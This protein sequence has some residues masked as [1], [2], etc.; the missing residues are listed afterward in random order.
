MMA[1]GF[2]C[3]SVIFLL[4]GASFFTLVF[5]GLDGHVWIEEVFRH[6][7]AG[8]VGFLIFLNVAIFLLAFFLDFFEIAFIVLPLIGPIA[9][10]MGVD[11]VWLAVVLA[12]NLQTSFM[13]PPIWHCPL[14]LAQRDASNRGDRQHLLGRRCRHRRYRAGNGEC[15][16]PAALSKDITAGNCHLSTSQW[17]AGNSRASMVV[18]GTRMNQSA[19][20]DCRCP[21]ILSSRNADD[22]SSLPH[23]PDRAARPP[24]ALP[25]G[26]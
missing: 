13:H 16:E 6:L 23:R 25:A 19:V 1:A 17:T 7:P 10:G 5:R 14:Q 4:F 20:L 22:I 8:Q 9:R 24:L 18:V 26:S 21:L 2:L 11:M 3:S 15:S 12:V